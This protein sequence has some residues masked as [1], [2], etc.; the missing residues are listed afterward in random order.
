MQIKVKN[1]EEPKVAYDMSNDPALHDTYDEEELDYLSESDKK[2]I[3]LHKS[4][5]EVYGDTLSPTLSQ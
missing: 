5:L 3:A 4:L 1:T 2:L